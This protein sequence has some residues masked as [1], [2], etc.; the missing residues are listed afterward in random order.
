[1][2]AVKCYFCERAVD[3]TDVAGL[4]PMRGAV[5]PV[6]GEPGAFKLAFEVSPRPDPASGFEPACPPC[7]AERCDRPP[8]E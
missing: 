3:E 4:R 6:R 8:R 2:A 7:L 1:M 5:D